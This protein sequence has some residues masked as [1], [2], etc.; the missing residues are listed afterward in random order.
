[1]K[2]FENESC[3]HMGQLSMTTE[4]PVMPNYGDTL[5]IPYVTPSLDAL[6][7]SARMD[8]LTAARED[9]TPLRIRHE[10]WQENNTR[11]EFDLASNSPVGSFKYRGAWNAVASVDYQTLIHHGVITASAGNHGLGVALAVQQLNELFTKNGFNTFNNQRVRA[12][13]VVPRNAAPTKIEKI[14]QVGG[15][16]VELIVDGNNY[17]EAFTLAQEHAKC[18]YGAQFIHPYDDEK[19]VEGQ[20]SA[21]YA[22][23]REIKHKGCNP[24]DTVVVIPVGGGGLLAGITL[25]LLEEYPDP[26]HRPQIV[27]AQL[28]GADSAAQSWHNYKKTGE[29]EAIGLDGEANEF[30]DGTSV[31]EIGRFGLASL[32]YVSNCVTVTNQQLAKG[33]ADNLDSIY[34]NLMEVYGNYGIDPFYGLQEP[35][36]M[37]AE[38]AADEYARLHTNKIIIN[39]KTGINVNPN[40]VEKILACI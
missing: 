10:C 13:I 3:T 18:A 35:A 26:D 16:D 31:T 37:I 1:M 25:A 4:R 5:Y 20:R 22:L 14:H 32:P 30:A 40:M 9:Y 15:D 33:Y 21:G 27:L 39:I 24:S 11:M 19:T 34:M 7:A 6:S 8:V 28:E 2:I 12:K 38:V 29:L 36:S 23:I 17:S